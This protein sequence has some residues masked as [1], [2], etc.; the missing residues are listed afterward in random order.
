[1]FYLPKDCCNKLFS[2]F[3]SEQTKLTVLIKHESTILMMVDKN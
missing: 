1:L 2:A 3:I